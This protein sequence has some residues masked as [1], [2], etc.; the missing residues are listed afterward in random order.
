LMRFNP[1]FTVGTL[2]LE[3]LIMLL[4]NITIFMSEDIAALKSFLPA[5]NILVIL[6]GALSVISIKQIEETSKTEAERSLLKEHLAQVEALVKTLQGERHEHTRHIQTIQAMLYLGETNAAK[7]YVEG[8]TENYW[9]IHDLPYVGN[10]ALSALLHA[11]TLVCET[12]GITFDFAIK[13]NVNELRIQPWDLSSILGNLLDNAI[14]ATLDDPGNRTV[15][16]EI[17]EEQEDYKIYVFN[18]G[19]GFPN[20]E[21]V[22]EPGFTTKGSE[23]RGYGLFLVRKLV[24]KYGGSIQIQSEPRTAVI[25]TFP[26]KGAAQNGKTPVRKVSC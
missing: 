13:C 21:K 3:I 16:L 5:A 10:P 20:K 14:E 24:I 9:H 7:E 1:L 12:K 2:L 19:A 18:T 23:A 8:V 26:K 17:K 22:F 6:I 11:K 15:G 4:I 25:V